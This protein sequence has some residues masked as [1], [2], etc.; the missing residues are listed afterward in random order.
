LPYSLQ[1]T[2][3]GH[4]PLP[5]AALRPHSVVIAEVLA[6]RGERIG[7]VRLGQSRSSAR[8]GLQRRRPRLRNLS[9]VNILFLEASDDL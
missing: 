1:Q 9:G 8:A 6:V 5:G 3:R 2:L 4:V 7:L